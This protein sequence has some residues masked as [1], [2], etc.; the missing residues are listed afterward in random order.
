MTSTREELRTYLAKAG[1]D[2][3][4]IHDLANGFIA[5]TGYKP[6]AGVYRA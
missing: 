4:Q 6:A 5:A 3:I 2:G 1:F